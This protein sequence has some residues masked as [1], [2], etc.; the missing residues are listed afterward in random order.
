MSATG[1]APRVLTHATGGAS[2]GSLAVSPDGAQVAYAYYTAGLAFL[3]V[4]PAAGGAPRRFTSDSTREWRVQPDWSPDGSKILVQE[5][6]YTTNHSN[7]V[8]VSFPQG[9]VRRLTT[10]TDA[11]EGEPRWTPDGQSVLFWRDRSTTRLMAAVVSRLLG[12]TQQ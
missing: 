6:N 4:V 12:E 1:G 2:I 3:E 10:T 7:L 11:Y 5:W 8:T 9:E